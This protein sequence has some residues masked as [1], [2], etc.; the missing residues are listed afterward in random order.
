[1]MKRFS[2]PLDRLL[3]LREFREKEAEIELGRAVAERDRL[4]LEL[5][6]VARRRVGATRSRTQNLSVHELL[7]IER[8]VARLDLERDRLLESIAKAELEVESRRKTY[9][10]ASRERN[11]LSRL[12]EKKEADWR[13]KYLADEAA[14]LDDIASGHDRALK[15]EAERDSLPNT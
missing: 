5:D 3:N 12:R 4:Q 9:I 15:A 1:M 13:R 2:W 8:Y 6:S 7:S 11:V 10:E 14:I